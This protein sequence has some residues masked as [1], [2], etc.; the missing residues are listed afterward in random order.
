MKNKI[1]HIV[2]YSGKPFAHAKRQ[3]SLKAGQ[4]QT[5]MKHIVMHMVHILRI[6]KNRTKIS[7]RMFSCSQ[8]V[9]RRKEIHF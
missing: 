6:V 5:R 4:G 8:P 9:T 2:R 1:K 3:Y 7:L